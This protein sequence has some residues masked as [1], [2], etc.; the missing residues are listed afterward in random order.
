MSE[1]L[2]KSF[3]LILWFSEG[4][5]VG[6]GAIMPGLS[7]GTLCIAF[8]IYL[9]L[10]GLLSNPKQNISKYGKMLICFGIGAIVGFV[11]LSGLAAW[12]MD[13]SSSLVTCFFIGLIIGTLPQLW[14]DAGAEGRTSISYISLFG[15]FAVM[16]IFLT[17]L[18][19]NAHLK[20]EENIGGF[21]LCGLLWGLSFIVPGLSSSTLLLFFGLYQPM[22]DGISNFD[23]GVIIPLVIGMVACVLL[24]SKFVNKAYNN[25]YN[26]ISHTI[27]GIVTATIIM[28]LRDY[29]IITHSFMWQSVC[30]LC[31]ALMSYFLT[32]VCD[33]I[34]D[35]DS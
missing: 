12:L 19:A 2:K 25:H 8:G 14:K 16:L 4:M 29:E 22:L 5:I 26:I 7:G 1:K 24:L 17:A 13:K 30:I 15:G 32:I 21:L 18:Q 6:F 27:I 31:G 9:P 34:T 33:K 20:I 11:G 3:N 23:F 28:I 10:I 35:K